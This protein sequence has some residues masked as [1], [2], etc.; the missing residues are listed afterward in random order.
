VGTQAPEFMEDMRWLSALATHR[1]SGARI[2]TLMERYFHSVFLFS[3]TGETV[4][5]GN[6]PGAQYLFA[7]CCSKRG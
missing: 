2:K 7:L 4:L 1:R 6:L 5:A 3:M